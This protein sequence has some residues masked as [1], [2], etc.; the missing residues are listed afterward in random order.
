MLFKHLY[1]INKLPKYLGTC[2][3][4]GKESYLMVD[5]INRPKAVAV[6]KDEVLCHVIYHDTY[7]KKEKARFRDK[8]IK[9][10]KVT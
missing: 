6:I 1:R 2:K 7:T 4:T 3:L 10:N 5:N 9:K 8:L